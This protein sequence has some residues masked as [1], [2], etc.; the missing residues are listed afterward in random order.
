MNCDTEVKYS[1]KRGH[2][3]IIIIKIIISRVDGNNLEK[4]PGN[5]FVRWIIKNLST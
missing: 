4:F 5:I 3:G 2:C 1:L